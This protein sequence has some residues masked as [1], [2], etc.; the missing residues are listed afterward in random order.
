MKSEDHNELQLTTLKELNLSFG[1]LKNF[2]FSVVQL[3]YY[4]PK[5]DDP[6]TTANYLMNV[7]SGRYFC[8]FKE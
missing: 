8:P 4:L 7:S 5:I 1:S 3:G 2:Y 6:C